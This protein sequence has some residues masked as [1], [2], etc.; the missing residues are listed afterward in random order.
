METSKP[1]LSTLLNNPVKAA[2][3]FKEH[4]KLP[5]QELTKDVEQPARKDK[6]SKKRKKEVETDQAHVTVTSPEK[7][8]SC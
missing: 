7:I 1:A 4:S 3:W 5:S 2:E 6:P 8:E